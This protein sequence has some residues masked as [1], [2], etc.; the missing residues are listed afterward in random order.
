MSSLMLKV[1]SSREVSVCEKKR[2]IFRGG[3]LY[4]SCRGCYYLKRYGNGDLEFLVKTGYSMFW[5]RRLVCYR[6]G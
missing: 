5:G 6:G 2:L 1:R 3:L 4:P